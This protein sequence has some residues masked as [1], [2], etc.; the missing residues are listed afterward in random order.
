MPTS[1]LD[2][3][4]PYSRLFEEKPNLEGLRVFGCLA[5][6]NLCPIRKHKFSYWSDSHTFIGYPRD[7]HGYMCYDPKSKKI[8]VSHDILFF[9][10]DFSQ[11]DFD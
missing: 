2:R 7:Y 8:I 1:I 5:Y 6:P 4:L 11:N 3:Y 9:E 10:S